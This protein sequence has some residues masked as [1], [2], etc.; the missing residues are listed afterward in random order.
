VVLDCLALQLWGWK[1][2]RSSK[3]REPI[4]EEL[5]TAIG[6]SVIEEIKKETTDPAERERFVNRLREEGFSG[7]RIKELF[8]EFISANQNPR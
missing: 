3:M 8:S 4:S 5:H 7:A 1:V 6:R 2:G